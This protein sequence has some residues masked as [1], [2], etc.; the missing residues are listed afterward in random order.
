MVYFHMV[1][2][3]DDDLVLIDYRCRRR[4]TLGGVKVSHRRLVTDSYLSRL[5]SEEG[6]SVSYVPEEPTC[7]EP[8]HNVRLSVG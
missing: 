8:C 3:E 6:R 4:V 7:K 2:L 5:L 1:C